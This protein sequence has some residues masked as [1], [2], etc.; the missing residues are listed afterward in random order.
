[1]LV[2][3]ILEHSCGGRLILAYYR[4]CAMAGSWEVDIDCGSAGLPG[5][6]HSIRVRVGSSVDV[7]WSSWYPISSNL[8]SPGF[9]ADFFGNY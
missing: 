9:N 2:P 6:V 7:I 1:M 3:M 5:D 8:F 4:R